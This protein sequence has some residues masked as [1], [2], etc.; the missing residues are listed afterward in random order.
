MVDEKVRRPRGA[1]EGTTERPPLTE[2][3]RRRIDSKFPGGEP[4]PTVKSLIAEQA[5]DPERMEVV[6]ELLGVGKK[7]AKNGAVL[8]NGTPVQLSAKEAAR[9]E[10]TN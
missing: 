8:D 2:L 7:G 9:K 10:P 5:K 1:R 6:D 4:V 3:E